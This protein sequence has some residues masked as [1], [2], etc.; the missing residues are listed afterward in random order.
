MIFIIL[1]IFGWLICGIIAGFIAVKKGHSAVWFVVGA[2]Y[3]VIGI[4]IAIAL[5]DKRVINRMQK[6]IDELKGNGEGWIC[7]ACGGNNPSSND[8]CG[9]CGRHKPV[10]QQNNFEN[11][12]PV[13]E[14]PVESGFARKYEN[15][16]NSG[17]QP[18]PQPQAPVPEKK[19]EPIKEEKIDL[20]ANWKDKGTFRSFYEYDG[21]YGFKERVDYGTLVNIIN[22][23]YDKTYDVE[24]YKD[25]ELVQLKGVP[26]YYIKPENY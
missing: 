18:Q 17:F 26:S 12:Q 22:R 25:G 7:D 16:N 11:P 14:K 20:T 6:E 23:N 3:G 2:L 21:K 10:V 5:V 8:Y 13:L 15:N 24:F 19:P 1:A 9:Y 4:V